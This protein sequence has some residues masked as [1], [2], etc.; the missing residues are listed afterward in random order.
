MFLE[1]KEGVT[2]CPR[3]LNPRKAVAMAIFSI[4]VFLARGLDA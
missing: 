2:E 4:I 1:R 3:S